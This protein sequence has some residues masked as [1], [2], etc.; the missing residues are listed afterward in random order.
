VCAVGQPTTISREI[1]RC[2]STQF[3]PDAVS[4]LLEVLGEID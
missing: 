4:M 3:D 1:L 2:S